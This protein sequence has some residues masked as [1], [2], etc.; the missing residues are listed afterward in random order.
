MMLPHPFFDFS[1]SPLKQHGV[2]LFQ[3]SKAV[4]SG[5]SFFFQAVA[6]VEMVTFVA[7]ACVMQFEVQPNLANLIF[8][9]EHPRAPRADKSQG[10]FLRYFHVGFPT[11]LPAP[12]HIPTVMCGVGVFK[13]NLLKK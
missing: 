6:Q 2:A 1:S 8:Y 3:V 12:T 13:N 5:K 4:V 11:P 9:K 7:Q 10:S